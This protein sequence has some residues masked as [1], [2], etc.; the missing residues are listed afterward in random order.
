IPVIRPVQPPC[1]LLTAYQLLRLQISNSVAGAGLI[2][3]LSYPLLSEQRNK[4]FGSV[5]EHAAATQAMVKLA[6]P[7]SSEFGWLRTTILPGLLETLHRNVSRGFRDVALFESALVFLPGERIG[8]PQIPP[9]G[10]RPS[11]TVLADI[12]TGIPAQPHR[13]AAVFAGHVSQ[14]GPGHTPRL[15]DWQ[16]PIG[17]ALDMADVVGAELEIRQ[18]SHQAF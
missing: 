13:V 4:V 2:E 8:T 18:G 17:I 1:L 11:A 14:P 7:I 15:Y 5:D 6:N 10:I 16:D 3:S 12:E 9:L